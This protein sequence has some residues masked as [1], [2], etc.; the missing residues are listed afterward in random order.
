M[1]FFN[2]QIV[3]ITGAS[4]G[5]GY[6]IA[7]ILS[8]YG[9][10]I[11]AIGRNIKD[12]KK[13]DN[14]I[15]KKTGKSITLVPLDLTDF[16]ALDRLGLYIYNRWKK[17]DILICNAAILQSLSPIEHLEIELFNKSILTNLVS[18]WR[19]IRSMDFLLK[20]SKIAK[21]LFITSSHARYYK[22][23]WGIQSITKSALESLAM[24]YAIENVNLN[25]IKINLV[26]PGPVNTQLRLD[27]MPGEN[28][29]K[30][31]QPDYI[32]FTIT[33][34]LFSSY[35]KTGYLYN[36]ENYYAYNLLN[37]ININI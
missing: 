29:N 33:K 11:I 23:F 30:I 17:L 3:L 10:H 7:R 19:I 24:A 28:K 13:L 12:L 14:D 35:L 26:N 9:A 20:S 5:I 21:I 32:A 22:P 31:N 18:N 6:N 37:K 15:W 8:I 2:N 16:D 1:K 34:L 4:K 36:L 27:I 25:N